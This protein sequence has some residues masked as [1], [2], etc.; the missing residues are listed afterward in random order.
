[1]TCCGEFFEE[2]Y[3]SQVWFFFFLGFLV[4]IYALTVKYLVGIQRFSTWKLKCCKRIGFLLFS[5]DE[6]GAL[7]IIFHNFPSKLDLVL[8]KERENRQSKGLHGP[9][10]EPHSRNSLWIFTFV[11]RFGE[12]SRLVTSPLCHYQCLQKKTKQ[13]PYSGTEWAVH[14]MAVAEI[15]LT[16]FLGSYIRPMVNLASFFLEHFLFSCR[17]CSCFNLQIPALR[18]VAFF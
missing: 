18:I 8:K 17:Y 4:L 9:S 10:G 5:R 16:L 7:L 6:I 11:T 3:L 12:Q 13:N 1:M 14:W 15:L 2:V